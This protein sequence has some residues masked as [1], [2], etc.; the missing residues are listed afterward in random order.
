M[1]QPS[2]E[3]KF[4]PSLI[5]RL[6]EEE[7]PE[8][9]AAALSKAP[10]KLI[11]ALRRD[12]EALL[13]TRQANVESIPTALEEARRSLLA[14]GLPDLSAFNFRS[15]HDQTRLALLMKNTITLFEPRL[16]QVRV[17]PQ[18]LDG[19]KPALRFAIDG[20]LKIFPEDEHV[21]FETAIEPETGKCR[22]EA[23]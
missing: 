14:Y 12:L 13:N 3:L 15:D 7:A 19:L 21:I 10:N 2:K 20:V 5:D 1:Q 17:T 9:P 22:I 8:A 11:D 6:L 23:E 16:Q 4:L 18:P